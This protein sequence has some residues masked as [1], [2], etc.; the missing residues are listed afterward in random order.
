[1]R[2]GFQE[3]EISFKFGTDSVEK[4]V[5]KLRSANWRTQHLDAKGGT[6]KSEARRCDKRGERALSRSWAL[7][8]EVRER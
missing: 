3:G 6:R 5:S 4:V 7:T 1:M 2:K 8:R